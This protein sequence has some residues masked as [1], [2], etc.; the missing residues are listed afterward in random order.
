MTLGCY[1]ASGNSRTYQSWL[2]PSGGSVAN[3]NKMLAVTSL[4]NVTKGNYQTMSMAASQD[5][6]V[7]SADANTSTQ[8]C[9]Q[10]GYEQ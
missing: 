3:S 10:T 2:V 6:Y 8:I 5:F 7:I 1:N 9:W 4:A